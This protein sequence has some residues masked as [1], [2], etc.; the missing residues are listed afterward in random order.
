MWLKRALFSSA[1]ARLSSTTARRVML[2]A[3]V[4]TAAL[5][6]LSTDASP[7]AAFAQGEGPRPTAAGGGGGGAGGTANPIVLI[8]VLGALALA[9]FA[10]IMLT[11][12]VKISVVLS[13]LRNALGTQQVPP[14]QVITG[15]SLI[16][17]IFVMSPV[18]EKMYAEAGEVGDS[19]AIF[20][21]V[22]VKTIFEASKRGREPL[23]AFLE[24]HAADRDR[25]M[26]FDLARRMA[27]KNGNDPNEINVTDFRIVIPAFV[28]SQLTEAF[29]IGFLLFIPFLIIDMVVSNILQAM[30]MFMLSPTMISLPFKLLLF[31]LVDGW[32]ILVRNLVLGYT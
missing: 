4:L 16:L 18:V 7:L 30:G 2:A 15:I 25:K 27:V 14:N 22:S 31:V 13:I 9:P 19:E 8:I 23:R 20:S 11:S 17:T 26:F 29:K 24:R 28:T 5:I 6:F 21:E 3:A 10:L 12:F 32:V 1:S